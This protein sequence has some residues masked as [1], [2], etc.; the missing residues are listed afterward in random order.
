MRNSKTLTT[1]IYVH[2]DRSAAPSTG[3]LYFLAVRL[4][5]HPPYKQDRHTCACIHL[6]EACIQGNII[7]VMSIYSKCGDCP[8]TCCFLLSLPALLQDINLHEGRRL[9]VCLQFSSFG[10]TPTWVVYCVPT[11][12]ILAMLYITLQHGKETSRMQ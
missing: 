7:V 6:R 12:D 9:A 5:L 10:G 3:T 2:V 4:N 1:H 11:L 8:Y